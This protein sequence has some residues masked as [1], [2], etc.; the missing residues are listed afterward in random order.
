VGVRGVPFP[1]QFFITAPCI[2]PI[3]AFAHD[4][5]LCLQDHGC[6]VCRI[7]EAAEDS[8][9]PTLH[10]RAR[11]QDKSF[12]GEWFS[13]RCEIRPIGTFIT[14]HLIFREPGNATWEG[15]YHHFADE[16]CRE[17]MF[18]IY[19]RG[20]YVTGPLSLLVDGALNVDLKVSELHVTPRDERTLKL[21]SGG[22][23]QGTCGTAD[24]HW[25]LGRQTDVT[26]TGGCAQLQIAVPSMELELAKVEEE[27]KKKMLLLGERP[28]ITE[29]YQ[30]T[31]LLRP[32][33]FLP[34]LVQ[35]TAR[36]TLPLSSRADNVGYTLVQRTSGTDVIAASQVTCLAAILLQYFASVF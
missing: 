4:A 8:Y 33:S 32:T 22:A 14:R 15:Y 19:A 12:A 30:P 16:H 10:R 21:V 29:D 2:C 6:P 9:P 34:P 35:C 18:S 3:K 13:S 25:Q 11:P 7:I 1:H 23:R 36:S 26:G 5:L 24:T 27:H 17:P 28:V 31:T 20:S